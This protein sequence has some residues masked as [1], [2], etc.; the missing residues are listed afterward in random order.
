MRQSKSKIRGK[1]AAIY[2]RLSRDDNLEGESYM[3]HSLVLM[4]FSMRGEK[5]TQK[6]KSLTESAPLQL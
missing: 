3:V 2:V 5:S 1:T 6:T 4:S